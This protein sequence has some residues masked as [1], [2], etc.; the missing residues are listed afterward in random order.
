MFEVAIETQKL[1]SDLKWQNLLQTNA[2]LVNEEWATLLGKMSFDVGVSIDAPQSIHDAQRV[3]PSGGGSFDDTVRGI[4]LLREAGLNPGALVT[5]TRGSFSLARTTYECLLSLGF[6]HFDFLP[7]LNFG[8]TTLPEG[9]SMREFTSFLLEIFRIWAEQDNPDIHIRKLE[10]ALLG[11]FG[12]KPA[13]CRYRNTCWQYLTVLPSG[14]VYPC[15]KFVGKTEFLYG[16][17]F[18]DGLARVL[19]SSGR[20]NFTAFLRNSLEA[21]RTCELFQ[22]CKGGCPARRTLVDDYCEAQ[23]HLFTSLQR[24]YRTL[25]EGRH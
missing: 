22:L 13:G 25:L 12:G 6:D 7:C 8:D 11:V 23:K 1:R 4:R 3:Y 24:H 5:V 20:K 18:T 21:C 10:D 17:V 9:I 15:D 16:N 19:K 2:T 14:D